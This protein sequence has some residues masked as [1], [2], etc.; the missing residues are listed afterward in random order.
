VNPPDEPIIKRDADPPPIRRIRTEAPQAPVGEDAPDP[1]V[2][3]DASSEDKDPGEE[4]DP[5][6]GGYGGRDPQTE[7]PRLPSVPETQD[8]PRPHGGAPQTDREPPASG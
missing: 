2:V 6:I 1:N 4:L 5:G 3:S 7:M 8:D